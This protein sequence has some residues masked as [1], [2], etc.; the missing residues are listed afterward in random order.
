[1]KTL[2]CNKQKKDNNS[3]KNTPKKNL[4][5]SQ[6]KHNTCFASEN[7]INLKYNYKE[8]KKNLEIDTNNKNMKHNILRTRTKLERRLS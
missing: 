2:N 1:M 5:K 6:I 4:R 7:K 8:K 3:E